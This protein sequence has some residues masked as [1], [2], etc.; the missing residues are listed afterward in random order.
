MV[1]GEAES[2]HESK[3]SFSSETSFGHGPAIP[4]VGVLCGH[5]EKVSSRREIVSDPPI[6]LY[7]DRTQVLSL[8]SVTRVS[9]LT[10]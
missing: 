7:H 2:F 10:E 3:P 5:K 6:V 9:L 8:L 4:S 1:V